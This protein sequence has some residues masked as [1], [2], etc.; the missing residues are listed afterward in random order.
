MTLALTGAAVQ[1][2]ADGWWDSFKD[3]QLDRLIR[4][5]LKDTP[6]L[7]QAKARVSAALAQTQ[8]AQAALLPSANLDAQRALSARPG[9]LSHP[10][11]ARGAQLLDEPGRRELGLGSGFLG[12]P[13]RCRAPRPG[14]RRVRE[15]R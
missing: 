11:A 5:G 15:L 9:E 3:P 6:T 14:S 10:A 12:A 13:V 1:P 8:T 7:V 2:A 4:L